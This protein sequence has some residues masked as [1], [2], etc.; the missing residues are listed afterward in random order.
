MGK[1]IGLVVGVPLMF[2][3][4][5]GAEAPTSDDAASTTAEISAS[6]A[7]EVTAVSTPE[8]TTSSTVETTTS[9]VMKTTTEAVGVD[10]GSGIRTDVE[11]RWEVRGDAVAVV[12][13][14]AAGNTCVNSENPECAGFYLGW[15]ANFEDSTKNI[16]YADPTII[17]GLNPGDMI[18]FELMYQEVAGGSEIAVVKT[19]PFVFNG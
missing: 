13:V 5:G 8:T 17:N 9:T 6:T 7:A 2:V 11:I 15:Q 12:V 19:Y 16:E 1:K 18:D 4:C 10:A 3:A 14:D